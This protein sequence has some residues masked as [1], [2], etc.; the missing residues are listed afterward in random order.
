[1][2]LSNVVLQ[3]KS[4]GSE[5]VK[6]VVEELEKSCRYHLRQ[7]EENLQKIRTYEETIKD[8]TTR[9]ESHKEAITEIKVYL[10]QIEKAEELPLNLP[11]ENNSNVII[12]GSDEI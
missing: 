9:N 10:E 4:K 3:E 12:S 1:L 7:L 8:L 6:H 11:L 5:N 2:Q